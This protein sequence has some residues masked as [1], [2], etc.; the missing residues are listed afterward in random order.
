MD[1]DPLH[2]MQEYHKIHTIWKRD[3]KGRVIE[4]DYSLPEFE[5][6]AGVDWEWTEKIDGTNVR[7]GWDESGEVSFGGRT[8]NAQLPTKLFAALRDLFLTEEKITK[9][10]DMFI[11]NKVTLYG[12][13][14]GA[15]IQKGGGNYRPDQ[16]LILYDI[17]LNG[18]WLKRDDVADIAFKLG[19]PYAP[20]VGKTTLAEACDF[21]RHGFDS[22]WGPFEAEGLVGRPSLELF[23]RAGRRIITKIKC[24]DYK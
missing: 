14:Y 22:A 11:D 20:V 2:N 24:R 7:V 1:M 17:W 13:G 18:W 6:L 21:V 9:M 23:D 16:G 3:E 15:G 10:Q 12:E 8:S 4:G 19:I 5:Y